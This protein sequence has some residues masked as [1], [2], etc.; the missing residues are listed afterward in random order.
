M[1]KLP[2]KNNPIVHNFMVLKLCHLNLTSVGKQSEG[3]NKLKATNDGRQKAWTIIA[4]VW[5]W[6]SA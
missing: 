1:P 2:L 5:R 4:S 3:D 6:P